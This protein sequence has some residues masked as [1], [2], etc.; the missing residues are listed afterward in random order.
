MEKLVE[1]DISPSKEIGKVFT[2]ILLLS[3]SIFQCGVFDVKF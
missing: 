2:L 3:L 1:K